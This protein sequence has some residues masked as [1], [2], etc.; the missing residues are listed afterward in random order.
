M[1][2]DVSLWQRALDS[3][4]ASN[5]HA[6]ANFLPTVFEAL[7]KDGVQNTDD[8]NKHP[9][10]RLVVAQMAYLAYGAFDCGTGL[11]WH[12][13]YNRAEL[14]TGRHPYESRELFRGEKEEILAKWASQEKGQASG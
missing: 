1:A 5:L 14:E 4:S 7:K 2:I 3:Q 9:I 13:A 12:N 8:L 10:V 6:L 11:H